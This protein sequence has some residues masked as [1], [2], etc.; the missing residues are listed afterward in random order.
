LATLGHVSPLYCKVSGFVDLSGKLPEVFL[1][2]ALLDI[3]E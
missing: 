3:L 2:F 1:A